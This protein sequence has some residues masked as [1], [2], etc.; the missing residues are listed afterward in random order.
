[1]ADNLLLF[2]KVY[3]I[4]HSSHEKNIC[5]HLYKQEEM[6]K[7]NNCKAVGIRTNKYLKEIQCIADYTGRIGKLYKNI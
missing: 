5:S 4:M 6:T 3:D 7:S 1:M 2:L